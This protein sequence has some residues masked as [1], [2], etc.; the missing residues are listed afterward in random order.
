MGQLGPRSLTRVLVSAVVSVFLLLIVPGGVAWADDGVPEVYGPTDATSP[1]G[2]DGVGEPYSLIDPYS[3]TDQLSVLVEDG[4][5]AGVAVALLGAE[6]QLSAR[7]VSSLTKVA[8]ARPNGNRLTDWV[9][10]EAVP[11]FVAKP[12][13]V[14]ALN[15]GALLAY[16]QSLAVGPVIPINLT[17]DGITQVDWLTLT[18]QGEPF[19][20]GPALAA[21]CSAADMSIVLDASTAG[22]TELSTRVAQVM[23]LVNLVEAT[24]PGTNWHVTAYQG[25]VAPLTTSSGWMADPASVAAWLA[26][27]EATSPERPMADGIAAA[28]A[29]PAPAAPNSA[30]LMVVFNNSA[31]DL[32]V[33]ADT[34]DYQNGAA[35]AI[36][37]ANSARAAGWA[38]AA[39]NTGTTTD[40]S[41]EWLANVTRGIA[42]EDVAGPSGDVLAPSGLETLAQD[43]HSAVGTGCSLEITKTVDWGDV[44]PN[45]AQTFTVCVRDAYDEQAPWDCRTVD[46]DGGLLIW[47]VLPPGDYLVQEY[48]F[49]LEERQWLWVV[50]GEETVTV[51]DGSTTSHEMTNTH[52]PA[53]LE[54]TKTVDWAGTAPDPAETFTICIQGPTFPDFNDPG[55]CQVA[56]STG[57]LLTWYGLAAG[58]YTVEE[59][60]PVFPGDEWQVTGDQV[61]VEVLAD[62]SVA[63]HEMTNTRRPLSLEVTKV[64]DWNGVSP[65][66][67]EIFTVCLQGPSYPQFT[68]PG[69][70]E[71][72]D[73][74]GGVLSWYGLIAGDYAVAEYREELPEESWLW[75]VTGEETITVA[76]GSTTSH[77]MTNTH[78]LGSLVVTKAVEANGVAVD[79]GQVFAICITGPSHPDGD[80]QDADYDGGDLTW[81]DLLPGDYT[82]TETDPGVDW[83]ETAPGDAVTVAELGGPATATVTNTGV[84]APELTL[85]KA[86]DPLSYTA[87]GDVITYTYTLANSGNTVLDEPFSV[88][89]DLVTVDCSAAAASLLPGETTTCTA[90]YSVV[91]AD[92]EAG[93]V[94][95][96][97][98]AKGYFGSTEVT[99]AA[100]SVTVNAVQDAELTLTKTADPLTYAAVGDLI[101]YTYTLENSGNVTLDGPFTVTDDLVTVDCASAAASLLS[102]ETTTCTSSYTITQ[103]DLDAGAVTNTATAKGYFGSTEV[104]S[105]A[106]SVTATAAQNPELTLGKTAD[107]LTYAAVGDL[108]SYEYLVTNAGNVSLFDI[109]VV[110]DKATVTCPDTSAGLAPQ[111]AITCTA[112]HAITQADLDA[113][114]LTNSAYATDGTIQSAPAQATVTRGAP[115][116]GMLQVAKVVDWSANEPDTDLTFEICLTG[117]SYPLGTEAGACRAADHDGGMLSWPALTPG[118][119]TVIEAD[120]GLGWTVSG[121]GATV[122]VVAGGTVVHTI[123]NTAD[124]PGPETVYKQMLPKLWRSAA[125]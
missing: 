80:C 120:P 52:K 9:S 58:D 93:S 64:V 55:A 3:I 74:D 1:V 109:T 81:T 114:S 18:L 13:T 63:E 57:A 69:A 43:L 79:E 23:E 67:A 10:Y 62:G 60:P 27:L 70:C 100:D 25:S 61:T 83:S 97:A 92:I 22:G 87:V 12:F 96:T 108:I 14:D 73:Y 50:S 24:M 125:Y 37:Q 106:D 95:N 90:S 8:L 4:R 107:P 49:E 68:S 94:T 86:A 66:P 38:T 20:A 2:L 121:S 16:V 65:D 17:A 101:S 39:V 104:T 21:T 35:S 119:Y 88:Q 72:A 102:G 46:H 110:D 29:A 113:G 124:G 34:P 28:V 115:V 105:A 117:P 47:E 103:A 32:A 84:P 76:D 33:G 91:Q 89:D 122:E 7:P 5:P 123:T 116:V 51:A 36:E 53:S 45:P 59:Y 42:G 11:G 54:V 15:N 30:K 31:P 75:T 6:V 41:S 99:S 112:S 78:K 77:E 19:T 71:V 98:T 118:Q 40:V 82:V 48:R 26:S 111:A 44:T 85:T 56:G